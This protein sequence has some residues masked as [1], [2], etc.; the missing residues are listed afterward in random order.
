MGFFKGKEP[1]KKTIGIMGSDRG[2]GVTHLALAIAN[3]ISIETGEKVILADL[4]GTKELKRIKTAKDGTLYGAAY[5]PDV[6]NE[7]I[8]RLMNE[9]YDYLVF[10]FGSDRE[11]NF[12]EFLRCE[13]KIVTGSFSLWK[14]Q[15]YD[16]FMQYAKYEKSYMEWDYCALFGIKKEDK[17][18]FKKLYGVP[19]R[20]VPFFSNPYE[21]EKEE[22]LFL[23]EFIQGL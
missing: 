9:S 6:T 19:V 14:R 22:F 18:N 5:F 11:K 7:Q 1:K 15:A 20:E 3:F 8:P 23:Q 17:K 13:R 4:S 2:V 10:D 16:D 21:L 12:R